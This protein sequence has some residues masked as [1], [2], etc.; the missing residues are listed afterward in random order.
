MAVFS[1]RRRT[2]RHFGEQ[3]VPFAELRLESAE[4]RWRAFSVQVDTGAVISL[5]AR[6]AADLLGVQL[7]SGEPI[8]LAGV[9]GASRRYFVHQLSARV[10]DVP[11]FPLRIAF[12]EREEVPN[13]LGRLDVLDRF[14]LDF[15]ASLE[16]TRLTGPWLD[17]NERK[18]WRH[19]LEV[20]NTV[21]EKWKKQPLGGRVDEAAKRFLNRADSLVAA[22]AGLWKLH[23]RS[24]LPL[25]IRALFELS[26]QFEYMMKD[27]EPRAALYLDFAHITNY[28]LA[29][30]WTQSPGTIGKRLRDSPRRPNGERRY[31]VEYERVRRHYEAKKGSGN[32]RGHW[33]PGNLRQ[34]AKEVDRVAE[35][36]TI[37]ATYCA[38][39]HGDP[40][41]RDLP[42]E[43]R[44]ARRSGIEGGLWHPIA[45]WARL[46]KSIADAKKIVLSADAYKTL[47]V[48][49]KG[50]V[51]D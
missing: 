40:W 2:T 41:A 5:L 26:V 12:A 4:G 48:A 16:E 19:L 22:A 39:A 30:A 44:D 38:W 6:S 29:R 11:A 45:Y 37:Y 24:E 25:I 10:G 36:E 32:V 28:R 47:E 8:E 33:Y 7:Q 34:L 51:Q 3:W 50:M 27:P 18:I 23:R 35:Y 21:L 13:L 17:A 9:G 15:D 20:E 42:S 14:Q 1:W 46:L 43:P 31:R 49:A